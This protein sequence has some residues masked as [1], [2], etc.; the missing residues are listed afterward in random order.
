[1]NADEIILQDGNFNSYRITDADLTLDIATIGIN[2]L[3]A[4]T[5]QPNTWYSIWVIAKSDGTVAGLLSSSSINPVMPSGY[6]YKAFV[7]SVHNCLS[8]GNDFGPI[9]QVEKKVARNA[10][11]VINSGTANTAMP[12]DCSRA[13]PEKAVMVTG[14]IT[15]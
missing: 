3:D 7:G 15:L 9:K 5:E 4:G 14:D 13:L 6:I 2:G 12:V 8:A 1:M 11:A 10:V